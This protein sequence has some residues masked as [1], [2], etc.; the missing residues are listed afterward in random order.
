MVGH[1]PFD[2]AGVGAQLAPGANGASFGDPARCAYHSD[3][4]VMFDR[5]MKADRPVMF[6]AEPD[7]WVRLDYAW[8]WTRRT[9]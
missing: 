5:S 3:R 8:S 4:A 1:S 9:R 2:F 7:R 6:D